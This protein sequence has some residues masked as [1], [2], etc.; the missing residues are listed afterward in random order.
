M[1]RVKQH[2]LFNPTLII[3]LIYAFAFLFITVDTIYT[4][5]S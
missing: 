2:L 3:F 1:K 4:E 5:T